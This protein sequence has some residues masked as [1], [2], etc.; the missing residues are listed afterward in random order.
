MVILL[1]GF[2]KI[3]QIVWVRSCVPTTLWSAQNGRESGPLQ[4]RC[5]PVLWGKCSTGLVRLRQVYRRFQVACPCWWPNYCSGG[6]WHVVTHRSFHLKRF[7]IICVLFSFPKHPE[8][9]PL[10]IHVADD[11]KHGYLRNLTD[12]DQSKLGSNTSVLRT[13]RIVR[14]DIHEGR[15][16]TRHHITIYITKE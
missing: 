3:M 15:C 6:F 10:V 13:N 5:F 14:L 2:W 4:P 16:E 9:V 7:Q 8:Q 1:V 11:T 12:F